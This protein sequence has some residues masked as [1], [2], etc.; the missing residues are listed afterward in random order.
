MGTRRLGAKRL[1]ALTK[2]G[3]TGLDTLRQAGDAAKNMIVSHNIRRE[4]KLIITEIAI[5]L[6]GKG[7]A[8]IR[9]TGDND[10]PIG[11]HGATGGAHLLRWEDATHGDFLTAEVVV[12]E[13]SSAE[14]AM[15]LSSGTAVENKGDVVAGRADVLAGFITN[16]AGGTHT[17]D[18]GDGASADSAALVN[19]EYLYLTADAA[20]TTTFT[21][22]KFLVRLVGADTSWGF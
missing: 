13:A 4:G 6:Q 12:V 17:T 18:D 11:E 15:S 8:S 20:A 22:G 7:S 16:A 19:D 10:T 5:D 3:E 1:N 21:S 14:A 9:S 2:R